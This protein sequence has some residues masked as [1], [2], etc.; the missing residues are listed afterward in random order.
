MHQRLLTWL[1]FVAFFATVSVRAQAPNV[2]GPGQF[3]LPGKILVAKVSGKAFKTVAGQQT[4]LVPDME[5]E[6][7]AKVTTGKDGSAVLSFSNGATTRLGA[8]TE[9]TVEEFLQDPFS[10]TIKVSQLDKEPSPSRTK[11]SLSHGELV[12]DVKTLRESQGSKFIVQTPV[13][14]AGVR[15]TVFRIVFIPGANGQAFF[16]LTT[17]SGRVEYTA[18]GQTPG[19]GT[20]N[21]TVT[22]T[23]ATASGTAAVN[24]PQ[25]QE[26]EILVNVTTNAQGQMEI[27]A[28][29]PPPSTTTSVTPA[30]LTQITSVAVEIATAV[31][32]AVYTAPT[33]PS[34]T[35]GTGG[36]GTSGS[37]TTTGSINGSTTTTQTSGGTTTTTTTT[38]NNLQ[39]KN[40]TGTVTTTQ[41]QTSIPAGQLSSQP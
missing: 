24:V 26:I 9:L 6:Q 14:A 15:G 41:S 11:L 34:G 3:N 12:G 36:G 5:I 19:G 20:T 1:L 28:L 8:D 32:N 17:A 13:G 37:G 31:Q 4:D 7:N 21:G 30:N 25:G 38:T 2:N 23:T 29:P 16:Q 39:T 22:T 27:T 10:G 33:P 40:A 18:P 35:G